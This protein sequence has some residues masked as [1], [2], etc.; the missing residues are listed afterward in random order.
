M[1]VERIFL[2]G[3]SGAGKTT[4]GRLLAQELG[5]AFADSDDVIEER[6]GRTVEDIFAEDGEAAFRALE[7]EALD[8]LSSGERLVIATG[9]GAPTHRPSRAALSKGLIVW[10]DITPEA[11]SLRLAEAQGTAV[12]PLLAGDPLARLKAL[13]QGRRHLYER[14]DHRV[15][16]DDYDAQQV[17][18]KIGELVDAAGKANWV[19]Q[20][21]R[22]GTETSVT[23]LLLSVAATVKT[24]SATYPVVVRSGALTSVGEICRSLG[25]D[26]NAFVLTDENVEPLFLG[27]LVA[28]LEKVDYRVQTLA[29]QPG[30]E[31]KT[32]ESVAGVYE[33]LLESQVERSDFVVCLGGGV[34]TDLGGFAAATV[35]RGVA[36]VHV[37]TTMAG[38]VDAAIGGKTG[39]DHPRGKNLV[40]AFVQPR[41]VIADPD[42]LETLPD[43]E[44]R[45][46][47]AELIKH[48]FILDR[49]LVA[50]LERAS[51]NLRD[52]A[53]AELI[54]RSVA[55]KAAV[56]S[57]DEREAGNR[58]LLNYGHTVG[59]ALESLSGYSRFLH[60]EAVAIGMKAAGTLSVAAGGLEGAELA[61]QQALIRE[62]GLPE[63][64]SGF[65]PEDII[66]ATLGDK[67]VR[68]GRVNW[69]LLERLGEARV[70]GD[71]EP[72]AVAAAVG[73]V[74]AE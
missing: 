11:A 7:A 25:L 36:F 12:R 69:V 68:G 5:W 72:E 41:A 70:R 14:S 47:C 34:V 57:G 40:G 58:M 45:A 23:S 60:G 35:L 21:D 8:Q 59:H 37:P 39:V 29:I 24:V 20:P 67:K 10:L 38:M 33:W 44:F 2:V 31:H 28:G 46:G 61:R 49:E 64:A 26:G 53:S 18:A 32:L 30:E 71:I 74:V 43:R 19:A 48:G 52:M 73:A 50:D 16:V 22:F 27:P 15:V 66:Q 1:A 13:S 56:V 6:S 51:T 55:I 62:C 3:L 63:S 9:G 54:A 42:V 65:R 17:A 4:S